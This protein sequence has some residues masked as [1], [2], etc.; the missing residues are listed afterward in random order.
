MR[1][2]RAG[3]AAQ[4][5]AD[6]LRSSDYEEV[7]G[8]GHDPYFALLASAK[9]NPQHTLTVTAD[10]HPV[11]IFGVSPTAIEGVGSPWFL[12]SY[13]IGKVRRRFARET[14]QWVEWMNLLY[15]TL[16]NYVDAS[17][18]VSRLWLRKA[19]FTIY[20]PEPIGVKGKLYSPFS[21]TR[22]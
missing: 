6:G 10:D 11:A 3:D 1:P 20:S 18:R 21:R 4:I 14:L 9:V 22:K 12:A 13:G 15:P 7:A 16:L 2:Y 19:G 8:L 17:N 5:M